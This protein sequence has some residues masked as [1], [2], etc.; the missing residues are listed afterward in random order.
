MLECENTNTNDPE[1]V[2]FTATVANSTATA[3]FGRAWTWDQAVVELKNTLT[4]T[5][6]DDSP[7]IVTSDGS[8]LDMFIEVAVM[9]GIRQGRFMA[10]A[11]PDKYNAARAGLQALVSLAHM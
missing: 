11:S 1:A 8:R 7:Y 3:I 9:L 10:L 4:V 2:S 5:F 6:S